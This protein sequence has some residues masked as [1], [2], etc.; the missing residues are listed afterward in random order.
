MND[1]VT[2]ASVVAMFAVIGYSIGRVQT[3]QPRG[4]ASKPKQFHRA[5]PFNSRLGVVVMD[6][7]EAAVEEAPAPAPAAPA[8]V[9]TA[10][11][12]D[13]STMIGTY[14]WKDATGNKVFD[15]LNLASKYDVNWLR[16]AELKH[17]RVTMLATV[18]FLAN[19]LGLKFPYERFQGVSSVDA[20]D[21]MVETGD[22]WTLLFV[23]GTCE[24][25]HASKIV[26][27]L[28]G[29]WEGWEPGNYGLDPFG[30]AS[31]TMRERELKHSRLAM[32]AFGGLVTQSALG[33]SVFGS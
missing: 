31:D 15:P 3:N 12:V 28:D 24:L 5:K 30:W 9:A 8:P 18:G 32:I 16:E 22:M 26:P 4:V 7:E 1:F 19:D 23:V 11:K 21:K 33:Y 13:V 6:E 25:I 17:G 29:D 14:Q 27:R 2:G 20:H 10:P